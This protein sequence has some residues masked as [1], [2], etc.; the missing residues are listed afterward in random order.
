MLKKLKHKISDKKEIFILIILLIITATITTY[1]NY[2][3]KKLE[4]TLIT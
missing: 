1:Y 2:D 4:T 3:Q